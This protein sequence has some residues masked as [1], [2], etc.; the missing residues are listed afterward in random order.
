M[1]YKECN[2]CKCESCNNN[3][4]CN[5]HSCSECQAKVDEVIQCTCFNNFGDV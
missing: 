1:K 2:T 3:G 5:I 4:Y